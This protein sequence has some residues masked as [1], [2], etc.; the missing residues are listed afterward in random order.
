MIQLIGQELESEDV[1][2]A[3][4]IL[5]PFTTTVVPRVVP[6][7]SKSKLALFSKNSSFSSATPPGRL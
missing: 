3:T 2:L 1:G 5:A 6:I 7:T 4:G